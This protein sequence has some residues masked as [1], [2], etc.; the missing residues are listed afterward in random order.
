MG[1]VYYHR[2]AGQSDRDHFAQEFFRDAGSYEFVETASRNGVFYAAVRTLK[3]TAYHK[4]GEVWASV[5]LMQRS[6]SYH[7]FGYKNMDERVGPNQH[8]APARIL[9]AL[10]PTTDKQ[11]LEWRESCRKHL[12]K[13][14]RIKQEIK[15]GAIIQILDEELDF[16]HYGQASIFQYSPIGRRVTWFALDADHNRLF[17]CRLGADW[18][19]RYDWKL[20]TPA[21]SDGSP[22]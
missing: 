10:T 3:D 15:P 19:F 9:D 2:P 13:Q 1:W 11:A 18:A 8:G 6:R 20:V 5:V 22:K 14:E 7:N 21:N 17:R 12:A 4:K 16:K